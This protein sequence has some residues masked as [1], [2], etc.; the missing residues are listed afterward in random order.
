MLRS[1]RCRVPAE[2][3][4]LQEP[5]ARARLQDAVRAAGYAEA[6]VDPEGYRRGRLNEEL[7]RSQP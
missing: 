1:T 5:A 3:D 2:M 4:R 7:S 6:T